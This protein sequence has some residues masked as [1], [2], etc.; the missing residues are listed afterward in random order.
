MEVG[1]CYIGAVGRM[2]LY[3]GCGKD[4]DLINL[5]IWPKLSNSLF[6]PLYC[7]HMSL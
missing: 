4:G 3:Q 6:E 5:P 1:W 2:V 7:V